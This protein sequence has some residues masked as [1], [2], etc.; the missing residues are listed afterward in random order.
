MPDP[1]FVAKN[2]REKAMLALSRLKSEI[3]ALSGDSA[4]KAYLQGYLQDAAED[5]RNT[6]KSPADYDKPLAISIMSESDFLHELEL[7]HM[8]E[9]V[10]GSKDADDSADATQKEEEQPVPNPVVQYPRVEI[11]RSDS[12]SPYFNA[13]TSYALDDSFISEIAKRNGE[14]DGKEEHLEIRISVQE[15]DGKVD[16]EKFHYALK[17]GQEN[18]MD[19]LQAEANRIRRD[20][21]SADMAADEKMML[22]EA[23]RKDKVID[24]VRKSLRE[25][26]PVPRQEDM[27]NEKE[28]TS[29][30]ELDTPDKIMFS[31]DKD[32]KAW[33]AYIKAEIKRLEKTKKDAAAERLRSWASAT[34]LSFGRLATATASVVAAIKIPGFIGQ[35]R[36]FAGK[37]EASR[38]RKQ[39][40]MQARKEIAA[41]RKDTRKRIKEAD[42]K[43]KG[44]IREEKLMKS[45]NKQFDG[46]KVHQSDFPSYDER[47]VERLIQRSFPANYGIRMLRKDNFKTSKPKSNE[48]KKIYE[49][50]EKFVQDFKVQNAKYTEGDKL[51]N[52]GYVALRH[53]LLEMLAEEKKAI[54]EQ[55]RKI[56]DDLRQKSADRNVERT[57]PKHRERVR[58]TI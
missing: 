31:S 17:K 23:S 57:K 39:I 6:Y 55:Q 42:A 26:K 1:S 19:A 48:D 22:E 58:T 13:G 56:Y 35:Y 21:P 12:A 44:T 7:Q 33:R 43:L 11:L 45:P 49:N 36:Y 8:E 24:S 29:V 28:K 30:T 34:M 52:Y 18:L 15:Q 9:S 14:L 54:K 47:L 20:A 53:K 10:M 40:R 46:Q 4:Y 41:I 37:L 32:Y 27:N 3:D 50:L 25:P 51:T 5:Y 16:A 2:E 38:H